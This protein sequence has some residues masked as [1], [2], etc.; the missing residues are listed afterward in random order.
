MDKVALELTKL[1][2]RLVREALE[3]LKSD[4]TFYCDTSKAKMKRV[5]RLLRQ[6]GKLISEGRE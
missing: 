5:K 4:M 2:L 6:V 1:E 3:G